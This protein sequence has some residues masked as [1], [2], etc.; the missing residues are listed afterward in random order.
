[1][2][3]PRLACRGSQPVIHF[4]ASQEHP[5]DRR[6]GFTLAFFGAGDGTDK[7]V[8]SPTLLTAEELELQQQGG[9]S[10]VQRERKIMF[11]SKVLWYGA[12]LPQVYSLRVNP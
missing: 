11:W 6:G 8:P 1:L 3:E 10:G 9:F 5:P 4:T 12:F 2:C 7:A